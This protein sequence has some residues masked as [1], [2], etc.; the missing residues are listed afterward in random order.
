MK[1]LPAAIPGTPAVSAQFAL[2]FRFGKPR[3]RRRRRTASPVRPVSFSRRQTQTASARSSSSIVQAR[4]AFGRCVPRFLRLPR[5]REF[6]IV[7]PLSLNHGRRSSKEGRFHADVTIC[8]FRFLAIAVATAL[9]EEPRSAHRRPRRKANSP[10]SRPRN[11]HPLPRQKR[12]FP[13]PSGS[14][15]C[16]KLSMPNKRD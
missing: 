16:G 6:G 11:P 14:P 3:L 9:A 12:R 2:V 8:L 13:M 4:P 5:S 10:K 1:S 7:P 15:T